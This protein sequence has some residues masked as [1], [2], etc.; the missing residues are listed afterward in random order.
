[1]KN[2]KKTDIRKK[3]IECMKFF[4]TFPTEK[5]FE[6]KF[7]QVYK[8]MKKEFD[9]EYN[10]LLIE[11]GYDPFKSSIIKNYGELSENEIY[12]FIKK[13]IKDFVD[14]YHY[15]P[16]EQIY[17]T[18]PLPSIKYLKLRFKITYSLL[19][20][21]IHYD[22][23]KGFKIYRHIPNEVL[24][25]QVKLKVDEYLKN[26]YRLPNKKTFN[27]FKI[28]SVDFYEKRFEKT[29]DEFLENLG[30]SLSM[31]H[32]PLVY[33]NY[34]L[35]ELFDLTKKEIQKFIDENKT[36]PTQ[37]QYRKL[38]LPSEIY[39]KKRHNLTYNEL[40][41]K[42]GFEPV[43]RG[44]KYK[45]MTDDEVFLKLRNEI[46]SFILEKKRLPNTEEFQT[47]DTPSYGY[48]KKRYNF[49]YKELVKHLGYNE[50]DF[51]EGYFGL[52][53]DEIFKKIKKQIELFIQENGKKPTKKQYDSLEVP[54]FYYIKKLFRLTYCELLIKLD[55]L[56]NICD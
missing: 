37:F 34:T 20:K 41:L 43:N 29:Y 30:Y 4:S 15:V 25:K 27:K 32:K 11:I 21:K 52:T 42:L 40:L 17:K 1:M 3:I 2:S 7:P 33:K 44:E 56:D 9:L 48:I 53:E 19:L 38:S 6:R 8:C 45:Y 10:D 31:K 47:L 12:D 16:N 54:S 39:F 51:I 55:D 35:D 5:E 46:N 26:N 14:K 13:N 49:T 50:I 28:G 18:L 24:L 36:V 23:I 22:K